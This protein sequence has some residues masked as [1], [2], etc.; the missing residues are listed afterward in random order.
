MKKF[1][2]IADFSLTVAREMFFGEGRFDKF[3]P[4][5]Q[6]LGYPKEYSPKRI[7]QQIAILERCPHFSD[8]DF[9]KIKKNLEKEEKLI[10]LEKPAYAES[11][12]LI[13]NTAV[14]KKKFLSRFL[15]AKRLLP[16]VSEKMEVDFYDNYDNNETEINEK[17]FEESSRTKK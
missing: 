15:E 8:L 12:F 5:I 11:L 9:Q 4:R 1:F 3:I 17:H 14:Q 6:V 13:R 2:K 10:S 7:S 16:L